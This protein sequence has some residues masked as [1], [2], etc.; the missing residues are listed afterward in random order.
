MA[1][2]RDIGWPLWLLA[3]MIVLGIALAIYKGLG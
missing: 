1:A 2:K 3:F